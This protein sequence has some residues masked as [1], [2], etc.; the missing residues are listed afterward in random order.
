MEAIQD[1]NFQVKSK[2][3][4]SYNI[5]FINNI[6]HDFFDDNSIFIIDRKVFNLYEHEF[7]SII[8]NFRYL[9]IDCNEENKT[10][11]YSQNVINSLLSIK[12]RRNDR[13]I[14]FGGGITQDIVAFIASIIF[15]GIKWVFFPTTLLAQCDSCIG[16]KSSINFESYKNLIGT[17]KPPS[18]VFIYNKFLNSLTD[19]EIKSGIGEMFHYFLTDGTK[20]ANELSL[21]YQKLFT[22]RDKLFYFIYNSLII[23]KKIIEIDEFDDSIRHIFNYGHT[24]GH[25]LEAITNYSI[26]HGQ[27]IT[28]G[29]DIANYISCKMNIISKEDFDVMHTMLFNNLP[30]YEF[31]SNNIDEYFLALSKDKKNEGNKLGCILPTRPGHVKKFFISLDESLKSVILDYSTKNKKL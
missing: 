26:P 20:L 14:A 21:N 17:F 31:T 5:F 10:I 16:S 24:F 9:L 2:I 28:L 13:L 1:Y 11:D 27:A 7:S 4:D 6:K 25:A 8:L 30:I 15:R 19:S 29:L 23:K 3:N 12:I 18:D 22:N